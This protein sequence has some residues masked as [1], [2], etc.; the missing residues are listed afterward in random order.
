MIT[1]ETSKNKAAK[2]FLVSHWKKKNRRAWKVRARTVRNVA[3]I[4]DFNMF[5]HKGGIK[6]Y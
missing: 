3:D 2:R 6:N 5:L 4:A 1:A